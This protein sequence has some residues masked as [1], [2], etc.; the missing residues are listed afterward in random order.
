MFV[1]YFGIVW[2]K[3]NII[4]GCWNSILM[5]I[6]FVVWKYLCLL[7]FIYWIIF[8]SDNFFLKIYY[9]ICI[10][11]CYWINVKFIRLICVVGSVSFVFC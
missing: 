7:F 6:F 9:I 10:V 5:C 3:F 11:N 2:K 8:I 1:N 4:L